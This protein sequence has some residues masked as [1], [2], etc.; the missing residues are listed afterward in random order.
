MLY[1]LL[2][3]LCFSLPTVSISLSLSLSL[4]LSLR[5][6][7][8]DFDFIHKP[9]IKTT[10]QQKLQFDLVIIWDDHLWRTFVKMIF[11]TKKSTDRSSS[12]R[13]NWLNVLTNE[14]GFEYKR[15]K[16]SNENLLVELQDLIHSLL[17][18]LENRYAWKST[19]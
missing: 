5:H 9:I 4:F 15:R 6:S 7:I 1:F 16:F 14:L 11:V 17:F 8:I 13:G 10:I 18:H 3:E 12:L 19:L 2:I